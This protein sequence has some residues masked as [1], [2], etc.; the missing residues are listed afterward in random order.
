MI[1]KA[2]FIF[3]VIAM[4]AL[5]QCE[6]PGSP[7]F[8]LSSKIETPLLAQSNFRILGDKNALID[9]TND[10]LRNLFE[11]DGEDFITLSQEESFDFEDLKNVVPTIDIAP[12]TF[13]S[14]VGEIELNDFSSQDENGN[15]GE[16][17]FQ[18]LT[19]LENPLQKGDPLPA[20][21]SPFPVNI[22]LETDFFV[23]AQIK[24]G[25]IE[26]SFRNELGFD[27]DNLTLELY[28]GSN[29]LGLIRIDSFVHNSTRNG[30]LAI[31]ENPD[32]DPEVELS[33]L[34]ADVEI[35]WS[36]QTMADDAGNLII[37]EISGQQLIASS[38]HAVIQ[39]QEF[40]L[41]GSSDISED[42]FIFR[43]PDH[44]VELSE[45]TLSIQN[46]ISTIDLDIDLLEIS[47]PDL[48]T[49]P[50]SEAD[51][52]VIRFEGDQKIPRN[53]TSPVSR[54]YPLDD[55]RIYAESNIVEYN[56]KA[57][58]ENTQESEGI[59]TRIIQESDK[60]EAEVDF[61]N[62]DISEVFGV[63]SNRQIILNTD[64]SSEGSGVDIMNN[65]EAEVVEINGIDKLARKVEGIEFTRS[66]LSIHYTTNVD[67]PTSV[68]GAFLGIDANG[69]KS[70]LRGKPGTNAE[71]QVTDP[72]EKLFMNG[73]PI[74][75]SNLI[76]F[77]LEP[78]YSPDDTLSSTFDR[79]NSNIT[80]F[81]KRL[82]TSVRFVGFVNINE[83]GIAGKVQIPVRFDPKI[84]INIPLALKTDQATFTD[85]MAVSLE[86]LPGPNDESL[87]E[88]GSLTI[89][90]SNRIPLGINLDLEFLTDKD[91]LIT[92]VPLVNESPI[93]FLPAPLGSGKYSVSAAEDFTVIQLNRS[94]LDQIN[95]TR[96]VRLISGL[97]TSASDEIRIRGTDDIDIA[98]SG[99]FL[100]RNK[101][102]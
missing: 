93:E 102:D 76:K 99:K 74:E 39:P 13:E 89:R 44:Y 54:S 37:N 2:H 20:A 61:L 5:L 87:L 64:T 62:P 45:G 80:D 3:P 77:D 88:E 72:A 55:V 67:I 79:N 12:T 11:I 58:T 81:L 65:L 68:I 63:F 98:I 49:P 50:Y 43:E 96:N 28:S 53:N 19:G 8:T 4:L 52:L 94:Q 95:Q 26:I 83:E 17:S 32:T 25:G 59:D 33:E 51:S 10:D 66:S 48:R 14:E 18:D 30:A 60:V 34:N 21:Q 7:D 57:I 46:I 27:L 15:L 41:S 56:I 47:F 16:A 22:E 9:T 69:N 90:Y 100:I 35:S 97:N 31:V 86:S 73:E 85:T 75:S 82:P 84:S 23:S 91:E 29:S 38:V 71:V 1:K 78:G 40:F 6:T 36:T 92:A 101:I 42:E 70:F 24:S